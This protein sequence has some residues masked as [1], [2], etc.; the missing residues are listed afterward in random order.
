M[1]RTRTKQVWTQRITD[2]TKEEV[3][4][5]RKEME[6][7][8]EKMLKEMQIAEDHNLCQ[9]EDIKITTPLK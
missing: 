8:L 6:E 7:K 4:D 2:K 1:L 5:L 9:V 3:T